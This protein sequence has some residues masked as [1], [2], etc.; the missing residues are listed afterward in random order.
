MLVSALPQSWST[1]VS[2]SSLTNVMPAKLW[3]KCCS[4]SEWCW[5]KR[6]EFRSQALCHYNF[7]SFP[8]FL[9]HESGYLLAHPP[10]LCSLSDSPGHNSFL[11]PENSTSKQPQCQPSASP[12]FLSFSPFN[13]A[14][15]SP[16]EPLCNAGMS[17]RV[18]GRGEEVGRRS[19]SRK[20]KGK[21]MKQSLL[22]DFYPIKYNSLQFFATKWPW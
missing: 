4:L 9:S 16:K 21:D 15:R 12:I 2:S 20:G 17:S 3:F 18:A 14:C 10:P 22:N 1:V 13:S 5:F 6:T 11:S 7:S 8:A 19:L